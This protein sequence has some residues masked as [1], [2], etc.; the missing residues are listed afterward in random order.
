MKLVVLLLSIITFS[1][2]LNLSLAL[3]VK[4]L[5][6]RNQNRAMVTK[7]RKIRKAYRIGEN[8]PDVNRSMMEK[9]TANG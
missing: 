9:I 4:E 1:I 2:I 7:L 3:K 5:N 6:F 8:D